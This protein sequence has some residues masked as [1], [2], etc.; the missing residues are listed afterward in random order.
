MALSKHPNVL[1]VYGSFV[2]GSKLYIVTPYLA[3]GSCLDIMKTAFPEGLDEISIAT[4]LRQALEGL[5]YLHKNGHIHRDVKA[6]NLLMDQQG[7]VLLADFGVSSS[8]TDNSDVRKTFVGT[9]CW[10]APEVMEQAG[11]NY[12]ADI[13]SFGI[14]S[15]ELANGHAPFAKYPPMKVLMMT[16]SNAPPTL[17]RDNGKHKYSKTFKD[18][19]DSCLQKDPT[20]RPSAEKLLLH[21]FFK[22]AKKR[23]YLVKSILQY[24]PP[25]DQRPH[26]KVPQ[27]HISFEATE[28]W[29][30]DD[31]E[32][33]PAATPIITTTPAT[34]QEAL[35]PPLSTAATP[36]RTKSVVQ[37]EECPKPIHV[38]KHT[39]S[40]S[41]DTTEHTP[42]K[43]HI[44]FGEAIIR[45]PSRTPINNNS[46][47][48]SPYPLTPSSTHESNNHV[49]PILSSAPTSR[50][51][52]FVIED[53]TPQQ[54]DLLANTSPAATISAHSSPTD[55]VGLGIS[56]TTDSNS[57]TVPGA[58]AVNHIASNNNTLQ[59]G[60]FKKGRFSVNQTSTRSVTPID[61][62][63]ATI[64]N[65]EKP[66]TP[67]VATPMQRVASQDSFN[68]RKSRFEVKH[69][70]NSTGCNTPIEPFQ[71]FPLSREGSNTSAL[72]RDSSKVS[73]FSIEKPTTTTTEIAGPYCELPPIESRK[74]G[75]FELT[76]GD[77]QHESPQ[78]TVIGQSPTLPMYSQLEYLLRQN[79]IQKV[80]LQELITNM[81]YQR[82]RTLSDTTKRPSFSQPER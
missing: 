74:K 46:T 34:S 76:G 16:L 70:N 8:L 69:T 42:I 81:H 73:R 51:S 39:P 54:P 21:P 15:L 75:R 3:A 19:I 61:D 6:G 79:E 80:M 59:E 5:V 62:T 63:N 55:A 17:D 77:I 29:D 7:T 72:S 13:W 60:E 20:K 10:M 47:I 25:L 78:S 32:D 35:T 82:N 31:Q 53:N 14:T 50:K 26:K 11:Y 65:T 57:N 33:T 41:I 37:F 12:K 67:H 4:I 23:D 56:N 24:V 52:R 45:E 1:R 36:E 40:S 43:K 22:Q 48:D 30:F 44:S 71:S 49:A 9:P 38:K 66:Q 18:M 2:N 27:K 68:E 64:S 28:Q 58:M